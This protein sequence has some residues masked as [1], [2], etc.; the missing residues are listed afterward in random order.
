MDEF[1]LSCAEVISQNIFFPIIAP[2]PR[3]KKNKVYFFIYKNIFYS[4]INICL[5][6]FKYKEY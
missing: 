1:G 6:P 4:Q 3:G 2:S 5:I